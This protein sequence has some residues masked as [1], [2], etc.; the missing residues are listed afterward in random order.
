M[1]TLPCSTTYLRLT[2]AFMSQKSFENL[3]P[4]I[5]AKV[6]RA[7]RGYF[8]EQLEPLVDGKK[9]KIT[10]EVND[11]TKREFLAGAAALL[12]PIDWPEPF[13][14]VMIEAMACGTPVNICPLE[15]IIDCPLWSPAQ[16]SPLR[17]VFFVGFR[18]FSRSA[19]LSTT[20]SADL[21]WP[22]V[23]R[24]GAGSGASLNDVARSALFL[25]VP[26]SLT[27]QLVRTVEY[28][29][30]NIKTQVLGSF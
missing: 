2:Y 26:N 28:C 20:D 14:L 11:Q 18:C 27:D 21:R 24:V 25:R 8:K 13:G 1:R 30:C 22:S 6:P 12:F 7:G 19:V 3:M 5:A 9:I 15:R 10:G 29:R 4:C 17:P 16:I 23:V